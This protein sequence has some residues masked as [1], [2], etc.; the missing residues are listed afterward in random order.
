MRRKLQS[1]V[2]MLLALLLPATA[3]AYDFEVDGIYYDINGNEATVTSGTSHYTGDV[4]IP[5]AVTYNGTT[6]S[7]TAIGDHAFFDCYRLARVTIPSSVTAI[8]T[9]AFA[10]CSGLMYIL[11]D[12]GNRQYDCRNNCNAIIETASNTLIVGCENTI[13][14]NSVTAIGEGAFEG[15]DGLM[16]VDIPSSVTF[17]DHHAFWGCGLTSVQIPNTVTFIG[18]GAFSACTDMTSIIVDGGNRKYDS[19]NNCNAI[20]ETASNTLLEGCKS[21]IIPNTVTA[22]GKN[23]FDCC[24]GLTSID[25]PNSV[26]SIGD[27]AFLKCSHLTGVKIPNSVTSIGKRPFDM[28]YDL[29]SIIVDSGNPRYDSRNNCNAIIETASNTLIVGCETSTIPNSVASI[30]DY[31]F[32]LVNDLTSIDIPNS[33]TT[34]GYHA[35]DYCH[36]LTS[37]TIGN[38]VTS[39]GNCAFYKCNSLSDVYCF[40]DDPSA[41]SMGISVFS[42]ESSDYSGR[43]LHVP[44]GTAAAY[45]ADENW[46]PYFGQ[47]VEM[48]PET[49]L[50]GDVNLDGEVDLAD[51]N[52]VVDII[53]GGDGYTTIAD[54]NG[55][56]EINISDVNAIINIIHKDEALIEEHEWVDL[57]LPSGTLWATCNI[58]ASAPEEY[59]DYFAWGETE[60]KDYYDWSTYKWCNGTLTSLTKYCT[61]SSYGRVD[62]KT[63]LDLDDDAANVNWG[64]SWCMPT[65]EQL[66]ELN[67]CCTWQ[68]TTLNGVMGCLIIGPNGNSLFL[69]TSGGFSSQLFNDGI[70]G[71][72]W[73]RTL[74]SPDKWDIPNEGEG[75]NDAYIQFFGT[76]G[77]HV[78]FGFRCEGLTIRAVRATPVEVKSLY[79][80]QESLDLGTMPVETT[81]TGELTIVNNTS[82]V[83]TLTVSVDEPFSLKQEQGTASIMTIEVLD[84]S[85]AT[86]TVMFTATEPGEFNGNVTFLNPVLDGGQCV[87]PVQAQSIPQCDYVDLG[88]PSG[89]LWATC[90]VGANAPEEYGDYF[91][92]GEAEPKEVYKWETYKWCNGSDHTLTKYCTDS[93]FGTVDNKMVL[94]LEDDAAYVNMGPAWRMPSNSQ[95]TEL[96]QKCTWQWTTING[97]NGRL[98]TGPNGN[99]IFLPAAGERFYS[100]LLEVGSMSEYWSCEL[101]LGDPIC[102]YGIG[103]ESDR[104]FWIS[105]ARAFGRSVRAVHIPQD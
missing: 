79:I 16:S 5:A 8:G 101:G 48:E 69:P 4:T 86:V 41:V 61:R 100:S 28:C 42:L 50:I 11:V 14:P 44:Q 29:I 43:T 102:A 97:V 83:Q 105:G 104:I 23:A 2:L 71:Y 85:R 20:I 91:A 22:I 99:S 25:I 87:I 72:Y 98:V 26:V 68:W 58:G 62:G 45:Q 19:R 15:R 24:F 103:F 1:L 32:Y 54:V 55:D 21:T 81:R 31:A 60:P 38:S 63:E 46:Y 90:N 96:I 13:I 3:A 84:K 67:D 40:I 27:Y 78:W 65:L 76:S 12:S 47:I 70:C 64:S 75:S 35:F 30:G 73:S 52:A 57:G 56:G 34:I 36:R 33:V 77:R 66:Q 59:G 92:W 93:D 53:T 17:I 18:E 74:C 51:I 39:I 37:V 89:T 6:Y 9:Q 95:Q 7:V 49:G 80:E 94:D 10:Y 82:Q 88:L